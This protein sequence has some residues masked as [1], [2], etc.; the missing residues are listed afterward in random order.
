M[1]ISLKELQNTN[2]DIVSHKQIRA[3]CFDPRVP[4]LEISGRHLLRLLDRVATIAALNQVVL[5]AI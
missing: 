2:A 3:I 1:S 4:F 5:A